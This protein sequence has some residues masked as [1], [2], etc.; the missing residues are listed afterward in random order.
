MKSQI[1]GVDM[2]RPTILT[3]AGFD[4]SNGA[5][6][7]SD[8]KAMEQ[9]NAY[10]LSVI[11]AVTFQNESEFHGVRWLSFDEIK[12]QL[13][14]LASKYKPKCIKIG[15]VESVEVLSGILDFINENWPEAYVIWDPILKAT[16][17]FEFHNNISNSIK[18]LLKK[19]IHL[20][21][22]NIPEYKELFKELDPQSF[23][24]QFNCSLLIKGGHST[25]T[26]VCDE[27]YIPDE[28]PYFILSDKV[29]DNI[30]KHGTG[31]IL[32][33]VIASNLA[34]QLSLKEACREAHFYVKSFIAST[35][36]LLGYHSK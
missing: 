33:S 9:N 30:Q 32:S 12:M 31:C 6:I 17:G 14:S 11:T 34:N 18:N 35:S 5:G 4:P 10:G 29:E 2:T 27:L 26:S 23:V 16:A 22:P 36:G 25:D 20:I 28:K 1:N 19:G 15:L 13:D 8:I 24:D 3:I 21:T 7:G